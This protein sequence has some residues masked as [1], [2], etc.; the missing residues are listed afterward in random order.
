MQQLH[1]RHPR[2]MQK[3][4]RFTGGPVDE[5]VSITTELYPP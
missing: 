4:Q 2:P 5:R 1:H 3:A